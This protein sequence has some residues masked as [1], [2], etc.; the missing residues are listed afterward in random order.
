M[1]SSVGTKQSC[2]DSITTVSK[3]TSHRKT[4]AYRKRKTVYTDVY[5]VI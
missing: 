5:E 1:L 3:K 2:P 4:I